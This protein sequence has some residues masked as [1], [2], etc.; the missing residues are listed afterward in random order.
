MK[1]V[2]VWCSGCYVVVF[3]AL[4]E[5]CLV[6]YLARD[7][8]LAEDDSESAKKTRKRAKKR[9]LLLASSIDRLARFFMPV[10]FVIFC[11]VFS[12]RPDF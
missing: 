7:K 5:Y 12:F 11:V 4:T 2:D 6:L 1:A 9:R 8:D 3:T 10:A